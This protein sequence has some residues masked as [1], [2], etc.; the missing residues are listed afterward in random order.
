MGF[1]SSVGSVATSIGKKIVETGQEIQELKEEW[2]SKSD[3]FLIK[4]IR[5]TNYTE[6]GAAGAVF[7]DRYP[8]DAERKQAMANAMKNL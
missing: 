6:K 3:D 8:D 2:S 4:K 5:S 1:W 7:R